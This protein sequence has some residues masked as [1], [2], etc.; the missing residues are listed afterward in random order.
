MLDAV[1]Q[2][3]SASGELM[4]HAELEGELEEAHTV[5]AWDKSFVVASN[6]LQWSSG[7][8]HYGRVALTTDILC[9][10]CNICDLLEGT[11]LVFLF[12]FCEI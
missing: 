10:I 12:S 2:S 11:I 5:A 4:D 9:S 6:A 8:V 7:N 1:T 3:R